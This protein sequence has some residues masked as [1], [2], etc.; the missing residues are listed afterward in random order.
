MKSKEVLI[1][2][3]GVANTASMQAAFERLGVTS[4]LSQCADEVRDASNVVL[5]GVGTFGAAMDT[6]NRF[7]LARSLRERIKQ[8]KRTLAVC[9][10]LQ[11]L[12]QESDESPGVVGLG[13]FEGSV[14]KFPPSL[15]VPQLGWNW[16]D[17]DS[18]ESPSGY[19]YFANS[20]CVEIGTA[21]KKILRADYGLK[22]IAGFRHEA[23]TALQFHPELS[24]EF[25]RQIL[26]NWIED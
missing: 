6:L 5:P 18:A 25:G 3:T 2:K 24:G 14:R 23:L 9:V 22:F 4:R 13:L 10:G 19:A 7:G 11:V 16:V 8:G 20:Y 21:L 1:V 17:G 12:F 15:R 26:I